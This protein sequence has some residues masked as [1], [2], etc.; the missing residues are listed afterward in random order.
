MKM[1]P[2][3]LVSASAGTG[4]TYWIVQNVANMVESGIPLEH[5]GLITF[6]EAAASELSN[7]VAQ[8]LRE[9]NRPEADRVG[10]AP[11][12]TIHGFAL[13]LIRRYALSL[14]RT[15]YETLGEAP[16]MALRKR[17]LNQALEDRLQRKRIMLLKDALGSR[18]PEDVSK[19]CFSILERGCSL[20]LQSGD[21]ETQAQKNRQLITAAFG[22]PGD[23]EKLDAELAT[24]IEYI[25]P[26]LPQNPE[27]K[28]DAAP[29][30]KA[31]EAMQCWEV[32]PLQAAKL[33]A[34]IPEGS[35]K[36]E[37]LIK[38]LREAGSTWISR[39]PEALKHL[40][41]ISD[42]AYS[43]ASAATS[44]YE[45]GKRER[46]CLDFNDQIALALQLLEQ[47]T[48]DGTT[49]ASRVA[50]ELPYLLVD[51][52]QDTSPLQFRLTETLREHG[53]KVSYIG[54]LK[55]AIYGW[56]DADSRLMGALM[57]EAESAGRAPETLGNNWR[58]RKEL[59]EFN[60]DLFSGCF[61]TYG[62]PFTPTKA[63][64]NY[65]PSQAP[66]VEL[67]IKPGRFYPGPEY[68]IPRIKTLIES[69]FEVM[70][71]QTRLMRP[72]NFGD[73]AILERS[74]KKLDEWAQALHEAGIPFLREAEGWN[75]RVEVREAIAWLRAI[76][77]PCDTQALADTLCSSL[78]GI[79]PAALAP[80]AIAGLFKTP[81]KFLESEQEWE[82]LTQQLEAPEEQ[83]VFRDFQAKWQRARQAF[84]TQ[85][86]SQGVHCALAE[87]QA[88]ERASRRPDGSQCRANII[89]LVEYAVELE[90]NSFETLSLQGLTGP[91]LENYLMGLLAIKED[92]DDNRQ[93]LVSTNGNA[94]YLL[95]M[96]R[97]KGLEFP[98]VIIPRLST[99]TAADATRC[100]IRWP[101]DARS[102][103]GP[104]LFESASLA[105]IPPHSAG[106]GLQE[107][108]GQAQADALRAREELCLLYVAFTRARDY[109]MVGWTEKAAAGSLQSL[110]EPAQGD[111]LAGHEV[112]I[113][114]P[115]PSTG[116]AI[117]ETIETLSALAVCREVPPTPCWPLSETKAVMTH[118][119]RFLEGMPLSKALSVPADIEGS[120][121]GKAIHTAL[122]LADLAS[123]SDDQ[124]LR[125][126]LERR[127]D[128]AIAEIALQAVRI[129]RSLLADWRPEEII[130]ELPYIQ[131]G[132]DYPEAGRVD[133]L[134][135]TSTG[136]VL[137]D[138]KTE[139]GS[140][141]QLIARHAP[142]LLR[143][144]A[145][146]TL[147]LGEEVKLGL[148]ALSLGRCLFIQRNPS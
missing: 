44:R 68:F 15:A 12:S 132:S 9:R 29:L 27:Y 138:F 42:A 26:L 71:R 61:D 136:W 88:E 10:G 111:R 103:L 55:Q 31:R 124:A 122:R 13:S 110:L 60:N 50:S 141:K 146:A 147:L 91:T 54:D 80:L 67:V 58:S 89:R 93:P 87:L 21:Y 38:P 125:K 75:Q 45:T 86:L 78:V 131:K 107:R 77:N 70:D 115:D 46:G 56:R 104:G 25:C 102:F 43:L 94:V 106:T 117:A 47:K 119:Y 2:P 95:T 48:E 73:F 112:R 113:S 34:R 98:I 51:E 7:R 82:S 90:A 126:G 121:V 118:G 63:A 139:Q 127:W 114:Y 39:H 66:C 72:C 62:L 83:A 128:G 84:K 5:I 69:G 120:I 49:M 140:E 143:Y 97:V 148:V 52:F 33:A 134:V 11:I 4:K 74:N 99:K 145:A 41:E 30:E 130:R 85:T 101:Q 20:R 133:L 116:T 36:L 79:S 32:N 76:A 57:D 19:L 6:T 35:K 40:T 123:E 17:A 129:L 3:K 53:T 144:G 28:K 37:P 22:K 137:L 105:F 16:A 135:K 18:D 8:T 1:A 23:P 100:E 64:L 142:Q 108:L 92:S 65:P 14:G 81:G 59:V 24:A 96:H 109:L